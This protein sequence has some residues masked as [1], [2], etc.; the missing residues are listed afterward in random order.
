MA[1]PTY[2]YSNGVD[3]AAVLPALVN[4]VTWLSSGSSNSGRYF[5]DGSFHASVNEEVLKSMQPNKDITTEDFTALKTQ[6]SNSVA[7]Q[8]INAVFNRPGIIEQT[9]IF[10]TIQRQATEI[11]AEDFVGYEIFVAPEVDKTIRLLNAILHF[12]ADTTFKLYAY[13]HGS[14]DPFWEQQVTATGGQYTVVGLTDCYLSYRLFRSAKFYVGYK[15]AELTGGSKP[16]ID[17]LC[18][19]LTRAFEAVPMDSIL[20][21]AFETI[22]Y[23][24]RANGLNMEAQSFY[25]Y[26]TQILMAPGI[27][28]QLIGLLMAATFIELSLFTQRKNTEQRTTTDNADR[29]ALQLDLTGTL[30]VSDSPQIYGLRSKINKEVERVRGSFIGKQH[31]IVSYASY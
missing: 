28:D 24:Y 12:D 31:G 1:N 7:M 25:D 5:D 21:I 18:P 26:T 29:F 15:P 13:A 3:T 22:R 27:F 2:K 16:Y 11:S 9:N 6:Y 8:A 19:F 10:E 17:E 20:P 23:T 4:R 30:P 14:T